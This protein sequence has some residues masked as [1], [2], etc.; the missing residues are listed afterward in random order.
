MNEKGSSPLAR[1]LPTRPFPRTMTAGIIPARAGFTTCTTSAPRSSPDHP[2][3]RG[4]YLQTTY[5]EMAG[6]GSSPLAR[7]LPR[8]EDP[9]R[10]AG[11]IIPARAGFTCG[12][13]PVSATT[14]GSSPLARGL[15][16]GEG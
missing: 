1:G 3:S 8:G 6:Q 4:V 5:E 2:R 14:V 12:M 10:G 7:G 16:H 15:R 13:R 9:H 11:R